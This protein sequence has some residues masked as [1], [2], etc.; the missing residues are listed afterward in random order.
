[1]RISDWSSDVCSSDLIGVDGLAGGDIM[2]TSTGATT[3]EHAEAANDFTA[4]AASFATGPNSIITGGNIEITAPGAVDLGNS[5]AGGFVQVS[6]QSIA[7]NAID[8]GLSVDLFADGID[9]G[10]IAAG[11]DITLFADSIALRSEEHTSELQSLMR[12]SYA[13]FCLK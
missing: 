12:N 3:V 7:F 8:A 9:G 6:G 4:N 13:V 5:I 11:G 2:L 1:M 10:S